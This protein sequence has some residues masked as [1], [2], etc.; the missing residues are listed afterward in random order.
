MLYGPLVRFLIS[1]KIPGKT[2]R[3]GGEMGFGGRVSGIWWSCQWDLV[4][5]SVGFGG[6][7]S[8]I[9]WSCQ[10][11]LVVVSVGFGSRVGGIWWSCQWD[12]V[13]VSV[14]FGGRVSEIWWSCQSR[15]KRQFYWRVSE[16]VSCP[17]LFL[18]A[19]LS[20]LIL[21]PLNFCLPSDQYILH[22]L[23]ILVSNTRWDE[24]SRMDWASQVN[25]QKKSQTFSTGILRRLRSFKPSLVLHL[26]LYILFCFSLFKINRFDH[27][28]CIVGFYRARVDLFSLMFWL[29]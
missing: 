23:K 29:S 28:Y 26:L 15:R 27:I 9:W 22:A 4:V 13:V 8:G 18:R 21:W 11:D 5:V 19:W 12:L 6:R 10:W 2:C 25:C 16:P 1:Q 3:Q 17:S 7:V 20:F 14:G 24:N